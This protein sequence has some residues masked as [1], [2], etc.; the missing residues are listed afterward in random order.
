MAQIFLQENI[1]DVTKTSATTLSLATTYLGQPTRINVGGQQYTPASILSLS[2]ATT[3]FNGIDTGSLAANT[4]YYIYAIVQ[5][6]VLGMIISLAN[7]ATGPAG[8]TSAYRLLGRL[9]T[10]YGG[11]NINTVAMD[12]GIRVG[13]A[14]AAFT[15][16]TPT[17]SGVGTATSVYIGSSRT[18]SRIKVLGRFTTG[19]T[20]ASEA[21]MTLP[22]GYTIITTG[23][24]NQIIGKWWT[25]VSSASTAKHG[26]IQATDALAY[27]TFG[28]DDYT[29]GQSPISAL[30]GTSLWN[31]S[32]IVW[33]EF[34]VEA[35]ELVGLYT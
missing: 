26:T 22:G 20:A 17:I 5:N 3:G 6:N 15:Q 33:V 29:N 7:P 25:N 13:T 31:N 8:F 30:N 23:T 28:S 1:P 21:R 24:A 2:T 27:V 10:D 11:A 14:P 19:T 18:A 35:A 12:S 32:T 16:Y 4:L 34:E 9:R